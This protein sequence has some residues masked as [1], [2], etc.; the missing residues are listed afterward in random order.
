MYVGRGIII[1]LRIV[2]YG[3]FFVMRF[4]QKLH[5]KNN[6]DIISNVSQ[7]HFGGCGIFG[8]FSFFLEWT[9]RLCGLRLDRGRDIRKN[10]HDDWV[11]SACGEV[12]RDRLELSTS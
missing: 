1:L 3:I 6:A 4:L 10:T 11:V 8:S 9:G 5:L 12:A 2:G 7:I